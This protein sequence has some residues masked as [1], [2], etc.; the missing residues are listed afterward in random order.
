MRHL[1]VQ[2]VMT[3]DVLTARPAMPLKEVAR[4]L[5]E[6]RI[7]ALP[8]LD[9]DDR[10][11]GVVS[12]RDL[13]A[14]HSGQPPH[15]AHWWQ[16]RQAHDEVR[17]AAGDTAGAVM[18]SPPVTVEPD[19]MLARAARLMTE[20]EVKRLPV[21]DARGTLV[22]IVARHDLLAAFLRTDGEIRDEIR[23]E[24]FARQLWADPAGVE[25]TVDEGLVTLT[26][27]VDTR[28]TAELA[29]RLVR[30]VDGVIDVV[31]SLGYR[32][33]DSPTTRRR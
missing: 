10:L 19:A 33:D 4:V 17:R 12:E 15:T 11:V 25:V 20:H 32:I 16:P 6:H 1:T 2:D 28:S 9:V 5:S 21:V 29:E 31:S 27:T 23:T 18:S 24:V 26:G 8:V 14:K 7:S 3:R 22:G 13:L 30:R